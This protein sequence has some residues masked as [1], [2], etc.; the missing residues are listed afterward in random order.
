MLFWLPF[1]SNCIECDSSY[2]QRTLEMILNATQWRLGGPEFS[3]VNI[4]YCQ[5]FC[6]NRYGHN[7][8]NLLNMLWI[9][10]SWSGVKYMARSKL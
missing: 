6:C 2:S 7:I 1:K 5:R 4:S 3:S 8:F 9:E 10:S